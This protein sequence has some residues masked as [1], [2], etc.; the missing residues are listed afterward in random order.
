M[1][2]DSY[3][4]KEMVQEVRMTQREQVS[5]ISTISSTLENIN[6]HLK[7][8]NSKVATHEKKLYDLGSFRDKALVVW[9]LVVFFFSF[10]VNKLLAYLG[11]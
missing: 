5:H 2:D 8:L 11:F 4:I 6:E 7:Q 9:G 1:S 3:T 10:G